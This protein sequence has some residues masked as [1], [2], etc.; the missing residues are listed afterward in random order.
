MTCN[1]PCEQDVFHASA[2]ADIVN[3]QVALRGLIPDV[4]HHA[5]VIDTDSKVPGDS[6]EAAKLWVTT[7][8]LS[9]LQGQ[10]GFDIVAH[11]RHNFMTRVVTAKLNVARTCAKLRA[12]ICDARWWVIFVALTRQVKNGYV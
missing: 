2:G 5:N 10:P 3:N 8:F 4:Y 7:P 1:L 11:A 6:S 9:I 12:V